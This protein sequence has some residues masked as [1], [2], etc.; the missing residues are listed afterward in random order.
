MSAKKKTVRKK[1]VV[2]TYPIHIVVTDGGDFGHNA[3]GKCGNK[4]KNKPKCCPHCRARLE[5]TYVSPYPGG[6]DF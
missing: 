1:R 4:V 5:G 6:S 3:C 2:V